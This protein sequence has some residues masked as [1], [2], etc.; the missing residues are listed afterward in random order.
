MQ[1]DQNMSEFKHNFGKETS[2]DW[3][4]LK[5]NLRKSCI[6]PCCRILDSG[7][8]RVWGTSDSE[9]SIKIIRCQSM[10][11]KNHSRWMLN[12]STT[13]ISH[14]VE[15][16]G[17]CPGSDRDFLIAKLSQRN[18][19]VGESVQLRDGSLIAECDCYDMRLALW[20]SRMMFQMS[21]N[22]LSRHSW[23]LLLSQATQWRPFRYKKRRRG[24]LSFRS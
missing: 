20:E 17:K 8:G 14:I 1:N 7:K 9:T 11:R 2:Y 19:A 16:V 15:L 4:N 3:I 12:R 18:S 6:L 21:D 24:E 23:W 10:N 22:T 5:D 13:E